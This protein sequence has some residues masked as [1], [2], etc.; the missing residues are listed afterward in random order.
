MD[1]SDALGP[2]REF[3]TLIA[4]RRR[5]AAPIGAVPFVGLAAPVPAQRPDAAAA[6]LLRTE[7]GACRQP[8]VWLSLLL[9]TLGFGG[10][11]G[12]FTYIAFTY[13]AFTLTDE[14]GFA[15]STVPWLLILFGVGQFVGNTVGGRTADRVTGVA[16]PCT[17]SSAT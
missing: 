3:R 5:M 6:P 11:S 9:T 8:Q 14:S 7:Y 16:I 15:S 4:G 17:G 13:L 1:W 12:A 2:A 10:L